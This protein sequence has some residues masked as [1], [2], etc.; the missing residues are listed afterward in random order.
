M[1]RLL[2]FNLATDA[3]DPVLGFTTV[4]V[5][6]LAAHYE[7]VDVITMRV[8]RLDVAGNVHVWSVGKE[9]GWSEP[10]RVGE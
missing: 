6:R 5:N 4:W 3:D 8:G 10:R 9:R 7:A 2:V 1:T